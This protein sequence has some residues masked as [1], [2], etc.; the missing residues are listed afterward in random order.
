MSTTSLV[1]ATNTKSQVDKK[2][3]KQNLIEN[4]KLY[5][6]FKNWLKF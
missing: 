3:T 4:T 6:K 5:Q 2:E 1:V